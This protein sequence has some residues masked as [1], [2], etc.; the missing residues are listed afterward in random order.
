[1][2]GSIIT[3]F[4]WLTLK[5]YNTFMKDYYPHFSEDIRTLKVEI[6]SPRLQPCN[7]NFWDSI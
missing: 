5:P 4:C 7:W 2:P 6:I 1:M 3:A